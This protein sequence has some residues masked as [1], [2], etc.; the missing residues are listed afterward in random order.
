MRFELDEILMDDILFYMENQ[1]GDFLLD[2]HEGKVVDTENEDYDEDI[3]FDDDER[4]IALPEWNSGD[5][6]RL[7]EHFTAGLKNPVV[8]HEL[9][10]A[11]NSSKG[12]FRSFKNVLEQYPEVE[13]LWFSYK[14]RE[15]K[16]E[17]TAWYNSLRETWGLQPVGSEPE[18]I[19]SLV[20]EDFVLREGKNSD[21]ENAEAL[22]KL[23]IEER[24]D[25]NVS[26]LFETMNHYAFPGNFCFAAETANGD[27]CG[28]INA[29]KN[30]SLLHINALEVK[31]EYRGMGL[32]KALLEKLLEKAGEQ[33]FT[34]TIDL[35]AGVE[36]F[37]R[38][39]HL[40]E[41]KP[42]VQRFVRVS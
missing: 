39:L 13:K 34:V 8:R 36:Y 2:T 35:P 33:K 12:V 38:T 31:P 19:S 9:S 14:E 22:H 42:C 23:C 1:D 5:G 6:Y 17:V 41:F 3:D 29:I 21:I 18:D 32:G 37:S 25:E 15:M 16:R 24:K 11:L 28:Y 40:E 7:M 20:L 30:D 26:A 27:F 10:L 4:F